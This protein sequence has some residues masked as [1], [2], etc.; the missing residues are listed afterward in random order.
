MTAELVRTGTTGTMEETDK[1][2]RLK[3]NK[4]IDYPI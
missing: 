2:L 1:E 4:K 3:K